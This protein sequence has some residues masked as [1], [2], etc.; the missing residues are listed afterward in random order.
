M[1][2]F[3][4]LELSVAKAKL[5]TVC[6]FD[7]VNFQNEKKKCYHEKKKRKINKLWIQQEKKQDHT[8]DGGGFGGQSAVQHSW[9][10]EC[11]SNK[12]YKDPP[13]DLNRASQELF[14][15]HYIPP[16]AD[17]PIRLVQKCTR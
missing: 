15:L 8:C 11:H 3:L 17:F 5:I 6:L 9:Q 7:Y 2:T 13:S 1:L 12:G 14:E 10:R 16:E 4:P